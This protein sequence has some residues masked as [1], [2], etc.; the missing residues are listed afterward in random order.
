[1]SI[2][3]S[4]ITIV[5]QGKKWLEK[6]M[7]SVLNQN[8]YNLEYI[9]ID[10]GSTDGTIETIQKYSDRLAY[11][12]SEPD[13]GISDAMNKGV[14]VSTGQL[15][16]HLHCGD[17]YLDPKTISKI[18]ESYQADNW[19]WCFGNQLLVDEEDQLTFKYSPPRYTEKLLERIN[20]I[21]HATVFSERSLFEEVGG[22]DLSYGYAMDYHLWLRY[23]KVAA[24]QQ[25][26]LTIAKFLSGGKSSNF[27]LALGEE[28][29][30]K[31]EELNLSFIDQIINR[32]II[33]AR[34]VKRRLGNI[35]FFAKP[36]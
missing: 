35:T 3:V 6:T 9:V 22:F 2:K 10:G 21:P 12:V 36:L 31:T 1:M 16:A 24:P 18:V 30:A 29:R 17:R 7:E 28:L 14:Q 4:V 19:R 27:E 23:A 33:K 11:W 25:L 26:D 13:R 8:Y 5:Y 20:I 15:I 34:L 32:S